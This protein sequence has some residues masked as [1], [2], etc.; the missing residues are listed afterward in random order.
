MTL[1]EWRRAVWKNAD[2]KGWH[3]RERS[4]PEI[5]ILVVS[6]VAE[7]L[8]EYRNGRMAAW[9][10]RVLL[11]WR[12]PKPEGFPIELADVAIR[13]FEHAET[14]GMSWDD[15]DEAIVSDVEPAPS[16]HVP[17]Q[18]DHLVASLY[19][20]EDEQAGVWRG[21][22]MVF[23]VAAW[24]GIDLVKAIETKYSFNLTRPY[25]HGKIA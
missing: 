12:K 8:E 25:K 1:A 24:N 2:A 18:L 13:L 6:E 19:V 14:I 16:A 7:A 9:F 11:F 15:P 3:A 10:R 17:D 23:A 20:S 21:I 5:R 22:L 4:W